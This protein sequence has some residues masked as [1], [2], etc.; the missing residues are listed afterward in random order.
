MSA[1]L[2]LA[3]DPTSSFPL[4]VLPRASDALD[5]QKDGDPAV[6]CYRGNSIS[7]ATYRSPTDNK[8]GVMAIYTVQLIENNHTA[9]AASVTMDQGRNWYSFSDIYTASATW[10]RVGQ[11]SIIQ[12]WSGTLLAAFEH[13]EIQYYHTTVD[14]EYTSAYRI[15]LYESANNGKNWT[16][17][18]SFED[19]GEYGD[20][21]FKSR[22]KPVH[23]PH[24]RAT[25]NGTLQ[26]YY[27]GINNASGNYT[28]INMRQSFDGGVHWSD[29]Q[30]VTGASNDGPDGNPKVVEW[31][32]AVYCAF[33][34]QTIRPEQTRARTSTSLI[35]SSDD[36]RSWHGRQLFIDWPRNQ[37]VIW[38][39]L[40]NVEGTLLAVASTNVER[41]DQTVPWL[42]STGGDVSVHISV[43]RGQN[44]QRH[45]STVDPTNI[46]ALI[47]NAS[48]AS[49]VSL[50]GGQGVLLLW[51]DTHASERGAKP[52]PARSQRYVLT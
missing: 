23:S 36:G 27:A 11:G 52:G 33:E 51:T 30:E 13:R 50:G 4:Q 47:G 19:P 24:L 22:N 25:R 45:A 6:L 38:P 34:S 7:G 3:A 5:L 15:A 9:I 48:S 28:G 44:W 12:L 8:T 18:S 42:Q 20:D 32:D 46:G 29:S 10:E 49:F 41:S 31:N 26:V 35:R 37:D 21:P 39:Q 17:L 40:V 14:T 2:M 43:D 16:S 1:A